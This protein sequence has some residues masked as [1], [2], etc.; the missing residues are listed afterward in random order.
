MNGDLA[1]FREEQRFRQWWLWLSLAGGFVLEVAVFGPALYQQLVLKQPWGKEPMS[2][3]GLIATSV[4]LLALDA[5]VI[6][7]FYSAVLITEVR[8]DG[9]YVRFYP[10]HFRFLRYPFERIRSFEVCSYRP[11]REYGGWGIR[12]GVRGKA[13]NVSGDRG[14][15]IEFTDGSR[16]LIGT[17]REQ[18]FAAALE[19]FRKRMARAAS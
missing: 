14:V 4:I 15:Q 19:A 16:L 17:Q 9:L 3:A 18:E 5:A 7:L 8:S 1:Y 2:D 10:F 12:Y 6:G 13:Y 11:L